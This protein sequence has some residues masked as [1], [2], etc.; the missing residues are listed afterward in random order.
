MFRDHFQEVVHASRPLGMY[1][2]T[3]A[4]AIGLLFGLIEVFG[5]Q[6]LY[7]GGSLS[8]SHQMGAG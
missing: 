5:Y 1:D 2:S 7:C 4:K 6:R 8:D 3:A